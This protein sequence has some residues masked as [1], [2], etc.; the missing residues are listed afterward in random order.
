MRG[1][2]DFL[3]F[4]HPFISFRASS[5][6][7]VAGIQVQAETSPGGEHLQPCSPLS[8]SQ[9]SQNGQYLLGIFT[10]S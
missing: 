6:Q 5:S 7:G 2:F 3:G 9:P 8:E 10:W 1:V 4:T